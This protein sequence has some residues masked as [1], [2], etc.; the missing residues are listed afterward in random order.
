MIVLFV[1]ISIAQ[2]YW[3]NRPGPVSRD[4]MPYTNFKNL[5]K[6][7]AK[8]PPDYAICINLERN[9][10]VEYY[11]GRN[12]LRFPDSLAAKKALAELGIQKAVWITQRNYQVGK[13]QII[14]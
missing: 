14:Q 9:P 5:G 13:I 8:I 11:A 7:L 4:G 1:L 2:Y 10:M 3:I 6:S 12:I